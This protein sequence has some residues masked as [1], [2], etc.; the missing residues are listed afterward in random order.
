VL[1]ADVRS[2]Y[3]S[4]TPRTV[5]HRLVLLGCHPA[6]AGAVTGLLERFEAD[7]VPG[8]PI[9]PPP[10]GVLA[11]AVLAAADGALA[12]CGATHARWVD[13]FVVPVASVAAARDLLAVLREALGALGLSLAGE[14]TRLVQEP[15][16]IRD[17]LRGTGS[18]GPPAGCAE[19]VGVS[20]AV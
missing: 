18:S 16:L 19:G 10:S 13:D 7:G 3:A 12:A 9:G 15:A 4:L 14:K 20:S 1:L 5:F 17:A 8:L 11:N 2:C 6:E